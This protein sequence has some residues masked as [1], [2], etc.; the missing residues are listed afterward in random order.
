MS[1]AVLIVMVMVMIATAAAKP[2]TT[3]TR[4]T[5][6]TRKKC[7]LSPTTSSLAHL[8]LAVGGARMSKT[9]IAMMIKAI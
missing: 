1:P 9:I 5:T 6:T 3:A 7:R 2:T 4:M 8:A